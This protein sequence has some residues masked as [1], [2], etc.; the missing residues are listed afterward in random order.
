MATTGDLISNDLVTK[1]DQSNGQLIEPVE[2][3]EMKPLN[4][5]NQTTNNLPPTMPSNL[6]L[7]LPPACCPIS[8]SK[9]FDSWKRFVPRSIQQKWVHLRSE[10]LRLVEHRFFEWLIIA[11]ILASST[12]LVSNE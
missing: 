4:N 2:S 5:N 6:L 8:V 1:S 10:A 12:T 11:S 9:H 3:I 7:H